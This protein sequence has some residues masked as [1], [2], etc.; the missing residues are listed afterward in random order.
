MARV[1]NVGGSLGDDDGD[2]PSPPPSDRG[3]GKQKV[4]A[5]KKHKLV[6]KEVERVARVARMLDRGE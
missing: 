4:L 3:K 2:R 1:K 6:D 5:S